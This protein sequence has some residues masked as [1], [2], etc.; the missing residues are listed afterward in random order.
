MAARSRRWGRER[1]FRRLQGVCLMR[2]EAADDG[3]AN[4][5]QGLMRITDEQVFFRRLVGPA[6]K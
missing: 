3:R 5:R 2:S 1:L 6:A 4:E